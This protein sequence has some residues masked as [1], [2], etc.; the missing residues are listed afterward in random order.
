MR[1][2]VRNEGGKTGSEEVGEGT[3]WGKVTGGGMRWKVGNE[4]EKVV[5]VNCSVMPRVASKFLCLILLYL[6]LFFCVFILKNE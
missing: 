5:D 1:G 4:R 2:R 3:G 6:Y